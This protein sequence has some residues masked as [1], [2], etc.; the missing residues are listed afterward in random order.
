MTKVIYPQNSNTS[1]KPEC[2]FGLFG[3]GGFAREVMPLVNEHFSALAQSNTESSYRIFYVDTK[4]EVKEV[5]GYPLISEKDFFEIKCNERF[6][7]IAIGD[8]QVRELIS[9]KCIANGA[10]PITIRSKNSIIYDCNEIGQG[11]IICAYSTITSNAKI[12]RFFHS[13]I[14]SYVA[15]DCVIGDY[16]TFAPNVHC[17]GNVHIENH[18]YVGTGVVIKQGSLGKPLVIGEGAVV[19][20]GAIVTKDVA[21]YTIVVGNPAKILSRT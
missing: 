1:N 2:V 7:N 21:P 3:T 19:G 17:N 11:G 12:G 6:F 20:M 13:N 10:K 14:Y 16:V 9:N 15:H 8:S 4:P 18:V 5:N